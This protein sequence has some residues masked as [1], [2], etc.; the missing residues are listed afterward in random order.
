MFFVTSDYN[1]VWKR[2]DDSTIT[3]VTL[4]LSAFKTLYT[5]E[6]TSASLYLNKLWSSLLP[7]IRRILGI[8]ALPRFWSLDWPGLSD[9][10]LELGALFAGA[11]GAGWFHSADADPSALPSSSPWSHTGTT[12]KCHVWLLCPLNSSVCNLQCSLL[13]ISWKINTISLWNRVI[14]VM[15]SCLV[16]AFFFPET[17]ELNINI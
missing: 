15:S 8:R 2:L 14:S 1:T 5:G 3:W 6:E 7:K 4:A 11:V 17:L 13:Q 12:W 16:Y 9:F 10:S